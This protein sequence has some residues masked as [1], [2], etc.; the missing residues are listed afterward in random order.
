MFRYKFV[1]MCTVVSQN[2]FDNNLAC[3][4]K[5][6]YDPRSKGKIDKLYNKDEF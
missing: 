2:E 1:R 6:L 3:N 5:C 4:F